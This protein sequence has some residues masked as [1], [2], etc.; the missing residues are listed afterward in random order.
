MSGRSG[1]PRGTIG[2]VLDRRVTDPGAEEEDGHPEPG[3][4]DL[5]QI[6]E[7]TGFPVDGIG[8]DDGGHRKEAQ[9][10][11]QLLPPALAAVLPLRDLYRR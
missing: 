9:A 11:L 2:R 7:G 3:H 6:D 4:S 8:W 5:L 1:I 10:C